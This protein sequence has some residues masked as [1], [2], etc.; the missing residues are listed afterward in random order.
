[1]A[2]RAWFG[3]GLDRSREV[4]IG[5]ARATVK[6]SR[7]PA[8]G[9]AAATDKFAFDTLR[10]FDAERDRPRVLALWI[11]GATDKFAETP[12]LLDEAFAAR[13][14]FFVERLI[15]LPCGARAFDKAPR[16]F[17]IRVT[18]AREEYAE[19]AALDRHFLATV[20]AYFDFGFAL[21]L[22]RQFRRKVLNKI[23]IGIARATQEKSVAAD[24]FEQFALAA[25]LA[26]LAG[27]D[28]GFVGKHFVAGLIQV[29][30]EFFPK[31]FYGLAPVELAFFNFVEFFLE[32]RG[33]RHVEDIFETFYEQD[34]DA[35]ADHRWEG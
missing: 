19:A 3:E 32:A 14:A 33:E 35:F 25:L 24:A 31:L 8:S 26:L 9:D 34:A 12:V 30:D 18:R 29:N 6:N 20:V 4:P 13:R 11:A 21:G 16:R 2:L 17:A 7:A 5:I 15:G 27:R 23:A 1:A 28:A 10:A 22:L